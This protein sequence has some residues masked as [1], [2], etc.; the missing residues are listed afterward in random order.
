MFERIVAVPGRLRR[1]A[2]GVRRVRRPEWPPRATPARPAQRIEFPQGLTVGDLV[3]I[4]A[5]LDP[6]TPIV[7]ED[8][9]RLPAQVSFGEVRFAPAQA[10]AGMASC[11]VLGFDGAESA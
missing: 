3:R 2:P 4:T 8:G 9:S 5:G 11:V 7:R 1:R 6:R 10:L